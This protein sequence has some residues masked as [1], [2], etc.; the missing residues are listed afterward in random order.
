MIFGFA[1]TTVNMTPL[2]FQHGLII[3][4]CVPTALG[5]VT[6][7]SEQAGGN[8][9]MA[10]V[11]GTI[12]NLFGPLLSPLWLRITL[13]DAQMN[14][15]HLVWQLMLIVLLPLIVGKS[16]RYFIQVREATVRFLI[17]LK[18][19]QSF[20]LLVM[21]WTALCGSA[22]ILLS[23]PSS[24]VGGLFGACFLLFLLLT[25]FGYFIVIFLPVPIEIKK[26][27]V[28]CL[29]MKTISIPLTL[30]RLLPDRSDASVGLLSLSNV[31]GFIILLLLGTLHASLLAYVKVIDWRVLIPKAYRPVSTVDLDAAAGVVSDPPSSSFEMPCLSSVLRSTDAPVVGEYEPDTSMLDTA[32]EVGSVNTRFPRQYRDTRTELV[33]TGAM[34]SD[35]VGGF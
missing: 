19:L 15:E 30:I 31:V 13:A 7:L 34:F 16:L 8:P 29:A 26:P 17:P 25:L 12:T 24:S 1:L 22:P 33:P 18:L 32:S 3:F 14:I 20:V 4:M 9:V 35:E 21:P 10:T 28:V 27:I 2:E 6:L 11:L 23:L 5:T